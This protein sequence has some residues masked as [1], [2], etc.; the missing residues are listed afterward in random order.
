MAGDWV[1]W[2]HAQYVLKHRHPNLGDSLLE[3]AYRRTLE[4]RWGNSDPRILPAFNPH[5]DVLWGD[6]LWLAAKTLEPTI[7]DNDT[8]NGLPCVLYPVTKQDGSVGLGIDTVRRGQVKHRTP[9]GYRALRPMR[10]I[11]FAAD[12]DRIPVVM[13][14]VP[15]YPIQLLDDPLPENEAFEALY[16]PFPEL[17]RTYLLASLTAAI[18]AEARLGQPPML[19]CTGPS[20]SGKEQTIRLAAS[21][22]GEDTFKLAVTDDEEVFARQLG[23]AVTSGH[24]FL[25]FDEFGKTPSLTKKLKNLLQ[26]CQTVCWRPLHQNRLVRTPLRAAFFF[27]CIR[28]PDF[29]ATSQEFVRRTRRMHLHRQLPNWMETS[30]ND[31]GVW[32]DLSERNARIAN[33]ILTHA[34]RLSHEHDFRFHG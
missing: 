17:S 6:G 31:T 23:V 15:K 22:V 1:H 3:Q 5:L 12:D 16:D 13:R 18:C 21:F 34:W 8:A 14:P 30:G 4:S 20:G 26:I 19:L 9:P 7:V 33:S 2:H 32:R 11:S 28:F 29:L 25:V 10:G 27:P 24:R